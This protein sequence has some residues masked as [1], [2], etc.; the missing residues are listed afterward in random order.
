ME[1]VEITAEHL[2]T[3]RRRYKECDGMSDEQIIEAMHYYESRNILEYLCHPTF[4]HC[5]NKVKNKKHA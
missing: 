2:G 5:L 1:R 3:I 4:S